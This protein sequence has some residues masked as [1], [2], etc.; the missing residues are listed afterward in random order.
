MFI[1]IR[2]LIYYKLTNLKIIASHVLG[3]LTKY[4]H[5]SLRLDSLRLL[6]RLSG[7]IPYSLGMGV[8]KM[9][10]AQVVC[11]KIVL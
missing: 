10:L 8:A 11:R 7:I 2:E 5:V 4:V 6:V 9:L 1:F 3:Q